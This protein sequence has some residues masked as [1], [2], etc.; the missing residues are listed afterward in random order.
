[1]WPS[2]IAPIVGTNPISIVFF[3]KIS[4]SLC[5]ELIFLMTFKTIIA[6][7]YDKYACYFLKRPQ[8][9]LNL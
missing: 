6:N 9:L 7:I 5:K 1:M 3:L 4:N 8:F 2:W